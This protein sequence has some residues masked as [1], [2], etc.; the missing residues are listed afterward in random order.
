MKTIWR[1]IG[2]LILG[3]ALWLPAA[4]AATSTGVTP[5]FTVDLSGNTIAVSGRVRHSETGAGVPGEIGR[6]HV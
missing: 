4:H 2:G 6:A 3:G 1:T 5:S